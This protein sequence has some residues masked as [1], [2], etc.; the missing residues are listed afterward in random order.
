[1]ENLT[2]AAIST[3]LGQG[4]IGV[5]RISGEDAV[6]IAD[7]VFK[8]V[9]GELLCDAK[10]YTAHFG[11]VYHN[12]EKID[13]CVATVF[14]A[15]HSYTGEDVVE[16]SC[17]GGVYITKTVLRTVLDNG[18]VIAQ[19]GEF[20]KRAFLNGKLD[21]TQAEAVMDIIGAKSSAAAKSA[22]SVHEG[23][24]SLKIN[25]VKDELV[26]RAAHLCAWAD[27]PEEDIPEIEFEALINAIKESSYKL[28]DLLNNYD[29][30]KAIREGIDTVIVG[31]PNVGKS[32]LMNLI[33]GCD[34]SIVTDIAGTTRD[35]VEET[36]IVKDITLHLSDTAGIRDAD[37]AI[38]KIG[39][40]KAKKRLL[41]AELVIAVFDAST[42][43]C[44]DDLDLLSQLNGTN[45]IA[46]INK[47]D[48]DNK[49]DIEK[50]KEVTD[51]IVFMSAKNSTGFSD[52]EDAV[53]KIAGTDKFDSSSAVLC[54][55]RQRSL[56]KN[57]F[58]SLSEA[59][60]ALEF[61]MTYDAVTVALE[62]SISYLCELTGER[63]T[64][65]VVDNVF[66][67]FCVGK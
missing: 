4:G 49:I 53:E 66:H 33:A 21:L 44:D 16:F 30:G 62:E 43:L 41:S 9:S 50:I 14:R 47:E 32:T 29:R 34:K 7:K 65:T 35:I 8:K 52:F 61:G 42:K 31:R 38:E 11:Y 20:T 3:A 64:E 54:N 36:A 59:I 67:S 40:D 56:A 5:I 37:N 57:A 25:E 39:V 1:M 10:G 22:L 13:E 19:S 51:H 26:N 45:C 55:E 24:L 63:V 15:P 28:S 58:E 12:N 6:K 60:S 2:I 48:L 23:A 18:A 27:Y 17:H 46:V